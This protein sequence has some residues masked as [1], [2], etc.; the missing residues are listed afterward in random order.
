VPA[1]EFV[2]TLT[3]K[4]KVHDGKDDSNV[5]DVRVNVLE[6]GTLQI[7]GQNPIVIPEDSAYSFRLAD[8]KVSDPSDSYPQGFKLS[9]IDGDHYTVEG[10]TIRPRP[11]FYGNLAVRVKVA[12]GAASS[13]VFEALVIVQPVNDPPAFVAFDTAPITVRSLAEV[14]IARESKTIDVDDERLAFAEAQLDSASMLTYLSNTSTANILGIFD[15]KNGVLVLIG[16]ASLGEYDTVLQ[17]ITY[18]TADSISKRRTIRFRLNDG[19][20]YSKWYEKTLIMS[21]PELTLDIPTAFTPNN[22]DAN[23]TWVITLLQDGPQAQLD[24]K[25]YN[26]QGLLLFESDSFERQWDGRL[27]GELLP[28]DSYFFTLEVKTEYRQTRRKGMVTILR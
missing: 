11:D 22:D 12:K 27:N 9:V 8:L 7:L 14:A 25:V 17:S 13:H 3:I 20:A 19:E 26:R 21:D 28:A 10:Q 23:D 18:T 15:Q 6:R 1:A 2:G 24:L 16:D 5:F 4:V